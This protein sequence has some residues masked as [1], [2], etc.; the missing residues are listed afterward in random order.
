MDEW[1]PLLQESETRHAL[2]LTGQVALLTLMTHL[3][4][5]LGLAYA[6]ARPHWRGRGLLDALVTLPLVFPPM[7]T[8]FLLLM[9]LGRKGPLGALLHEQFSI[10]LI[11]SF[12]GVSLAAFLAGLPLVVKP[13]Q[14]ALESAAARLTEAARTLGKNEA[15]IF[16][17]VL[18]PN[19]RRALLAGLMLGLGRALGLQAQFDD[20]SRQPLFIG[21]ALH[22]ATL[23]VNEQGSQ[24]SAATVVLMARGAL[25]RRPRSSEGAGE[26]TTLRVADLELDRLK[27]QV[28]R[29]ERRIELQ[30]KEFAL[31]EYLMRHADQ[32]VT[33]TMLLEAV[34]NYHFDPRTNV[35]D[36]HMSNLRAKVDLPG[37][38]SLI[39]TVRGA[40]YRLGLD[41]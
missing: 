37:L 19:I 12:A 8:G 35:I 36:V 26:A 9:L 33:R 6:L 20:L 4:A 21:Q 7:A 15:E 38:P 5:G 27:R 13:V 17:F 2:W 10:E 32:V 11:F 40:G 39:H 23:E 28:R 1:L 31:L 14:S 24:A 29:G 41:S 25:L 22:Q 16:L 18:L 30:P 3:V 34:W